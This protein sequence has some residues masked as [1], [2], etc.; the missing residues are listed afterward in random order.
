MS[1][2]IPISLVAH[3]AF[4]PRRAWLEAM[5][6]ATDTHQ[7]AAGIQAHTPADDP[8]GSR[9]RRHRA[10]DVVSHDLGVIGRCDTVELDDDA[11][12]T[13]V[14]HKATPIRRRPEV[15][16]PMRVQV[17]LLAGALADMGYP[18]AGQAIYFTNHRTRVEVILSAEDKALAREMATATARTLASDQAP[19]PLEDDRRCS[20]CSHISVCL[21]DERALEPV[22]RRIVVADPDTQVLHLTTAGSRAYINRGRIEVSKSGEKLGTFPIERVQGLVVHGNVDLSS[23]LIRE[24]L[25]RSLSVVWCTSSGRVTGWAQPAQGPNGGPRLLQHVASHN[26]RIDLARQFIAAKIANQATL[27]RRHSTETDVVA[28]LRAL[29]RHVLDAPSLTDLFG[30][31]GEAA[32]RY[33][34]N[35]LTMIRPKIIDAEELAFSTRTRRP[36]RDPV[37]AALNFCYGLATADALRAVVACGLDPN[38]GF[39]HSSGRNKPALALD[40][41]EEFR[42]PVADSVVINAFNN[43]ELRTRDFSTALGT[44]RLGERGRRA[45]IAGYERRV[46]G[47]FRHPIFGYDVTWR[48]AMEIQARL[49]LGVIDGTQPRYQGIKIR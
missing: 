44:T 8:A 5:G 9:S 14:E 40:L 22:T 10:V 33:F 7:V 23:G 6:E 49:V 42:A 34:E 31:E 35:F 25:W 21:P 15:T 47:K 46:T 20:R 28:R 29:Q 13:V 24:L 38:A 30:I 48:R 4:C 39:L 45:L 27:L 43:G 37:N 2:L 11:A 18:V 41:V 17:A 26:G 16:E 19:P 3:H 1:E 36:A 32:A 12:M